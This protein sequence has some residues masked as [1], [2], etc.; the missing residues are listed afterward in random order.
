MLKR[1]GRSRTKPWCLR[2][3]EKRDAGGDCVAGGGWADLAAVQAKASMVARRGA[4]QRHRKF[5][6]AGADE[7]CEPDHLARVDAEAHIRNAWCL[8][9][10][11]I[12]NRILGSRRGCTEERIEV[13]AHH[14]P[15]EAHAINLVD[16]HRLDEPPILQNGGAIADL[17]NLF[18]PVRNIDHS[19]PGRRQLSNDGEEARLHFPTTPL[20][21]RP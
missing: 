12:E 8:E 9:S 21:V 17:E 14:E 6:S 18:Q 13:A 10:R 3:S 20:S 11:Y 16:I 2:S 7:P 19:Y 1:I 4:K 15:Y 5:R